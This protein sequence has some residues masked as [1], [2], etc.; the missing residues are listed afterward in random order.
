[1]TEG[2]KQE[3][4]AYV[5]H[6]RWTFAKTMASIPHEWLIKEKSTS[7]DTFTKLAVAIT[8]FGKDR[9]FYNKTYRYLELDGWEYW[10]MT[11]HDR[12]TFAWLINRAKVKP[13]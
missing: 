8:M 11:T 12:A 7:P 9:T 1:M 6:N 2:L 13:R 4:T 10:H 3:L 5:T